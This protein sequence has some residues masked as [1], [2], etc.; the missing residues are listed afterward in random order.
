MPIDAN[1]VVTQKH[2]RI[3]RQPGG[4]RPNNPVRY[5]GT[6]DQYLNIT[7]ASNPVS[8]GISPI[9]VPDPRRIGKYKRVGRSVE[10]P[11]FPTA[12]VEALE[13][14]GYIPFHLSDLQCPQ[15][16][17]ILTG[18][19]KSLD[20][21]LAGWE[22]YVEIY[23]AGEA[24]DDDMGDRT[25]W[26][27]DDKVMGIL[28]VTFD[29]IY[30]IGK[31]GFGDNATTLVDREVVAITYGNN[32]QCG[33]CGPADDG[34]NLIYAATRPSGVGSP[35]L[36][37]ELVYSVDGG[38]EWTN[39]NIDGFGANEVPL[40]IEVVGQYLVIL[41]DDAI[42]HATIN[43]G[44]GIPGSFTKVTT[45]FVAANS[46]TDMFVASPQEIYFSAEG[47]YIYKSTDIP[48]G[49]SVVSQASATSNNLYRIHGAEDGT[50][51]AVGA[52]SVVVRSINQ[53]RTWATTTAEPYSIALDVYSVLVMDENRIWTGS[54]SSGR[55]SYTLNGGESWSE[56]DFSGKGSG[57]VWDIIAATDE[58]L[59]FSHSTNAP[60]GR[61]F[62]SWNGGAN[63]TNESPRL[64]NLGTFDRAMRLALPYGSHP[65][66]ASN[67]LAVAGL[68]GNG[69][70]GVLL[71]GIA[72]TR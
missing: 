57:T 27:A 67:N 29:A 25:A 24:T 21:F 16:F 62:S 55:L 15:N 45:G 7:G 68:A 19:C 33:D 47:G 71:L 46:P 22:D 54:A 28:S 36:P 5:S 61:I 23:S 9:N 56:Q 43:A 37:A 65:T 51:V 8:G 6:Q 1:E 66:V 52:D 17:Y 64:Q 39:V 11:D 2:K 30:A 60:D 44:T 69:T 26:D 13:R 14:H 31:M 35:G 53:G 70:D 48:S 40:D 42:Y 49:V 50:L 3:F 18:K 63:W 38:A 32:I 12:T 72:A 4:A 41:G 59:Y 34:T 58:V 20:N 10:A